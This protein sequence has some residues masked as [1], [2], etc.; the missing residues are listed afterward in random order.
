MPK[1]LTVQMFVGKSGLKLLLV[2][3]GLLGI[4]IRNSTLTIAS[5][6]ALVAVTAYDLL[7]TPLTVSKVRYN[8]DTGKFIVFVENTGENPVILSYSIHSTSPVKDSKNQTQSIEGM[9]FSRASCAD[10]VR[11]FILS[12][13]PEIITV[14]P[15][16][17]LFIESDDLSSQGTWDPLIAKNVKVTLAYGDTKTKYS[18]TTLLKTPIEVTIT[19]PYLR[20]VGKDR[21]FVLNKDYNIAGRIGSLKE[22]Q[23][24]AIKNPQHILHHLLNG[25]IQRW[26]KD[27]LYDEEL[28]NKL[29]YIDLSGGD[30]T[31]QELQQILDDRI[32]E[33]NY[34]DF[35]G[36]HP[37]LN[38]VEPWHA[39]QLKADHDKIIGTARSMS[40][41]IEL[42]NTSPTA[43][44]I[45]H[46][47]CGNDF[48]NWVAEVLGD[49]KLSK[50]LAEVETKDPEYAKLK[51]TLLLSDR[52]TELEN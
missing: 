11:Q 47:R 9:D 21:H 27:T 7:K 22:L 49:N 6:G 44:I 12:D 19:H 28:H 17:K 1:Y 23:D 46:T 25:D 24:H 50:R 43:S 35:V 2:G 33:L 52:L 30:K 51:I 48:A 14:E 42:V 15:G 32:T 16:V 29:A 5:A 8:R 40:A 34:T 18:K 4:A 20:Q 31:L 45:F 37:L 10:P 13:N 26:V 36:R 3:S 41:L 39:F 38:D